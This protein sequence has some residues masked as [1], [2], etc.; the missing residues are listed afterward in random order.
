MKD[1][2]I[3]RSLRAC[4]TIIRNEW[5]RAPDPEKLSDE[6]M[7]RSYECLAPRAVSAHLLYMVEAAVDMVTAGELEKAMRWLCFIQGVIWATNG[8]HINELR[9]NNTD[10]E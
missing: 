9:K 1:I 4:R 7:N 8:A 5:V 2:T 10:R 6:D 3:F